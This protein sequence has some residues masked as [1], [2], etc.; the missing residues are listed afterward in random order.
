MRMVRRGVLMDRPN[1]AAYSHTDT[2][3][4]KTVEAAKRVM[5]EMK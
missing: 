2:H 1:Y 4:R 5:E 3:I